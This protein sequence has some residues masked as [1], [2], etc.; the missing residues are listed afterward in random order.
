[1]CYRELFMFTLPP[2]LFKRTLKFTEETVETNIIFIL[3]FIWN[4][5]AY[6]TIKGGHF[7]SLQAT[8]LLNGE[9][10]HEKTTFLLVPLPNIHRFKKFTDRLSNKPFLIWLL[11][12]LPHFKCVATL[13]CNISLIACFLALM[14]H[15]VVWQHMHWLV[16][17]LVKMALKWPI[18]CWCA[19]K[20]LLTHFINQF[21][22]NLPRNLSVEKYV[23]RLRFDRI[24]DMRLWPHFLAHTVYTC[25]VSYRQTLKHLVPR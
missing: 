10:M 16:W 23:N 25:N 19:V 14:F 3:S 24:M 11:K 2:F 18:M 4:D 1:M 17:V 22:A 5:H 6:W 20:K 8:T 7:V 9:E 13:P 12:T 15:K 21:S